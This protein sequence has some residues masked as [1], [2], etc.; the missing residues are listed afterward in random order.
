MALKVIGYK[1]KDTERLR[2]EH[3][4]HRLMEEDLQLGSVVSYVG[5]KSVPLLRLY[6]YKEAFAFE[7]F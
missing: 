3:K 2:I 6:R 1:A 7:G 5:N 4:F